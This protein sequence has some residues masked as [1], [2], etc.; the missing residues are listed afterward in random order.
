MPDIIRIKRNYP[1]EPLGFKIQGGQD[2]SIPLSVLGTLLLKSYAFI[3]LCYGFKLFLEVTENSLADHVGLRPGDAIIKINN[4]ETSW[5]E[6]N[7]AK[8]EIINAG[9]EV[10]ITVVRYLE[11]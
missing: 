8:Q 11:K 9:D 10:W 1:N 3:Y 6:H 4:A 7:R 5:M 2:F